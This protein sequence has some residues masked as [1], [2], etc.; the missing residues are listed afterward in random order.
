M[1]AATWRWIAETFGVPPCS[2]YG[3][4][5]VGV[6]VCDNT[7]FSGHEV[8]RGALGRPAPGWEVGILDSDGRPLPAGET[9]EI[10]VKRRG[11]WLRVKDR[12]WMDADGY[13]W[14]GGRSDDVIISAGW[15]LSALEI[16]QALL[17]HP[18]VRDAAVV[19]VPD[20]I[21]GQVAKA[22]LVTGR[23][24]AAFA[25]EVQEFVK[26]RLGRHEYPRH[27]EVI[28]ALP[29]TPAGKVDRKAVRDLARQIR[30]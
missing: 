9:G 5:E 28:G 18:D 20:D 14:H 10:A 7:G 12:G 23:Y 6:L 21:R 4:T 15:T 13:V 8:R 27:V 25:G 16:E 2:M 30:E 26:A 22:Y 19:A 3:S 17:A 11:E 1:D 24:D 29:R